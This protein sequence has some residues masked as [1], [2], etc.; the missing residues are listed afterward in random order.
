MLGSSLDYVHRACEEE[1]WR[2]W[3]RMTIEALDVGTFSKLRPGQAN[4]L[5]SPHPD[6]RQMQART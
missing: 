2:D 4:E 3:C 5:V 6:S 1:V